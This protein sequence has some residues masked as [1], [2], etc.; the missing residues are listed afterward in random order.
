[1]AEVVVFDIDAASAIQ[2]LAQLRESTLLLKEEQKKLAEQVKAGN[3]TSAEA[4]KS[5]EANAIIL[6]NVQNE[7][8]NLSRQVEGYAE[9][10]RKATDTTNFANNSIQQNRELLKQLTAQYINL[11][12]PPAEATEI[13]KRLSDQL[14][15]QE[16]A[17]GNNVRNVGNY[18]GALKNAVSEI[19]IF[20]VSLGTL[21]TTFNDYN[22][23]LK[24]AKTQLAAYVTGQ[25]AAD[26]ATKL[27][28]FSTA[29]LSAAM[30]V[31]RLALIATGIGAFV[32][33]LG[34]L[35]AAFATTERGADLLE[36]AIANVTG[37]FKALF[38][39]AQKLGV[40]LIDI[41]SNPKKAITDLITFLQ[42]NLINRLQGFKVVLDGILER[43]TKKITNGIAQIGTGVENLTDKLEDGAKKG[44]QFLSDSAKKQQQ[45]VNIQR[46]LEDLEGAINKRRAETAARETELLIIAK[47]VN[48]TQKERKAATDEIL[49]NTAELQK[50]EEDIVKKKIEELKLTQSQTINDLK[51]NKD[52]LD[53]EA[54][55]IKVQAAGK[56]KQLQLIKLLNKE[57][58]EQTKAI[59]ETT[60]ATI[61]YQKI[62]TEN[63][64]KAIE[65]FTTGLTKELELLDLQQE[66]RRNFL[67][68][69]GLTEAEITAKFREE[70]LKI[71]NDFAQ[72]EIDAALKNTLLALETEIINL[73]IKGEETLAKELEIEE[74]RQEAILKNQE[75]TL[76]EKEKLIAESNLR[77]KGLYDADAQA[78]IDAEQKKKDARLGIAQASVDG[79]N[80]LAT[81]A[82]LQGEEL[83][84]FQKALALAQIGIDT[85]VAIS[86]G[87]A[88]ATV[89]GTGT[90][91]GAFVA[92][93]LFIAKTI[94]TVLGAFAKASAILAPVKAPPP[95][96][97]AE[98]GEIEIGGKSHSQG[99]VQLALDGKPVAEVEQGEGLFVMKKNAYQAI[100]HYSN[101]NKAFGGKSWNTT[102]SFLQDGGAINTTL[103]RQTAR[104]RVNEQIQQNREIVRALSAMPAPQLSIVELDRKTA[105][106]N[107]S[108]RVSEL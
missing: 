45:I 63:Q 11:K 64:Q 71:I 73:E 41:F 88:G 18:Q 33:L 13:I 79:L 6:K 74:T 48:S 4:A 27:S 36:D 37:V 42:G 25:R 47:S 90:G 32:V 55:L 70:R 30:N 61:D 96:Q 46:E 68:Q 19:N 77:I 23:A 8:R 51:G 83:I 38:G 101:I 89:S 50:L 72:K 86:A 81:L 44:L 108:V 69:S 87:I 2:K 9:V 66:Q 5:Y 57:Q 15:E 103:P 91:V 78:A 98:G 62:A 49:K 93:P 34:S 75:L 24:D 54:E 104:I 58:K 95:P 99:G 17:I 52:L 82:G 67:E 35:V 7:Q 105:K 60:Q 31:L 16:S 29:G 39:E 22:D 12:N 28:I 65:E 106:R 43:D 10:Q 1:M 76:E 102:S 21:E 84:A 107:K 14:K 94:A 97:F 100:K 40:Q 92:T 26:G 59:K 80:A 85:A 56:D 3:A 20:G 53:L